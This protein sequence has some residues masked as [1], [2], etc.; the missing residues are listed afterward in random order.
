MFSIRL[1]TIVLIQH[2]TTS[3]AG[4][5][6]Q[7]QLVP[8]FTKNVTVEIQQFDHRIPID[9]LNCTRLLKKHVFTITF[10][11]HRRLSSRDAQSNMVVTLF[12]GPCSSS[13]ATLSTGRTFPSVHGALDGSDPSSIASSHLPWNG[14][15]QHGT[16]SYEYAG[17]G[18]DLA[19][20]ES[21]LIHVV[22]RHGREDMIRG[23]YAMRFKSNSYRRN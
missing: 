11:L 3:I 1:I 21:A 22:I 16:I 9:F 20:L 15:F 13:T 10:A 23:I 12:A 14:Q 7:Q 6:R 19:Q 8:C 4:E 2:L 18:A 17:G 5:P